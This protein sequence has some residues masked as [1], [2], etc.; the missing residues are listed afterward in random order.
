M[1]TGQHSD[2]FGSLNDANTRNAELE[3]KLQE[4]AQ[5]MAIMQQSAVQHILAV[6]RQ[7]IHDEVRTCSGDVQDGGHDAVSICP[8]PCEKSP[9]RNYERSSR[10]RRPPVSLQKPRGDTSGI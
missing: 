2:L 3:Q 1:R 10:A 8:Q 4:Y 7:N 6:E 9:L 5:H